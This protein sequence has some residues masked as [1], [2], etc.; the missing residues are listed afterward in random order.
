MLSM[1]LVNPQVCDTPLYADIRCPCACFLSTLSAP[2]FGLLAPSCISLTP[3]DT[4]LANTSTVCFCKD[5]S[6]PCRTPKLKSSLASHYH[7]MCSWKVGV[8]HCC[9]N[10]A[11]TKQTSHWWDNANTFYRAF[12]TSY[13]PPY[14]FMFTE[15]LI[16]LLPVSCYSKL[17]VS[18][19]PLFFFCVWT[20]HEDGS[21]MFSTYNELFYVTLLC[22]NIGRNQTLF[23]S[24]S[25]HT[26][27]STNRC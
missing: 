19:F 27:F 15:F 16:H 12:Y 10:L 4:D 5:T 25:L 1:A 9:L 26:F 24:F 18:P 3:W 21:P 17:F 7:V 8:K 6:L 14:I 13:S 20:L 11:R 22:T 23:V 2:F